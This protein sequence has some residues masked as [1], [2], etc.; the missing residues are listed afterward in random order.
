MLKSNHWSL[1]MASGCTHICFVGARTRWPSMEGI[2]ISMLNKHFIKR[3]AVFVLILATG[4]AIT[5]VLNIIDRSSS[6]VAESSQ[7]D[8]SDS[9]E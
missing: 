4:A 7:F 6:G 3:L 5:V 8:S 9:P 2:S 1:L